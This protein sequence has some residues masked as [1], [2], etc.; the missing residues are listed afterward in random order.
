MASEMA[1]PGEEGRAERAFARSNAL[2]LRGETI[3]MSYGFDRI[4]PPRRR[5]RFE[6]EP[7][8]L[9]FHSLMKSNPIKPFHAH[10]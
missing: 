5:E 8:F 9:H 4:A 7:H 6:N 10:L 1:K 2:T 3:S